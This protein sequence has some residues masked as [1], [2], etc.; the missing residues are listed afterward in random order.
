MSVILNNRYRELDQ[1]E[2]DLK[3][4]LETVRAQKRDIF[5][6]IFPVSA[7]APQCAE[8]NSRVPSGEASHGRSELPAREPIIRKHTLP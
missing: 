7:E 4:E 3:R 1:R 6:Q 5:S 8:A 2:E